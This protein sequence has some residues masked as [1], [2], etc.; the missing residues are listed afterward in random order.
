[1]NQVSKQINK[2]L[3]NSS[4]IVIV[5]HQNPDGD[6]LGSVAALVDYLHQLK[7]QPLIFC[8][9]QIP[10]QLQFLPYTKNISQDKKIFSREIDTIVILDCGDLRYAGINNIIPDHKATIIN[11]DH[12]PTNE[13]YGHINYVVPGAASTTEILYSFFKHNGVRINRNMATSLLTGII[14]DTDNFSNPATSEA[15]LAVASELLRAG[16]NLNL[17][18]K[19]VVKNKTI[20]ILKLWGVV[21]QRLNKKEDVDMAYTYLTKKDT[22]QYGIED[23]ETEGISNFLNKLDGAKISLL[24]KETADGKIKGSFRTTRDDTDVSIIAKKMGGGGHKK[25]AGFTSEGTI[26]NILQKILDIQKKDKM[27]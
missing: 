8:S 7:Q 24:I 17:I 18:H 19:W 15:S 27:I 21:F 5:T 11:I 1:M 14:N 13:G 20:N 9:T 4:G 25:A 23:S 10:L 26:E 6:A 3:K 16:A 22:L 2:Q 12:H